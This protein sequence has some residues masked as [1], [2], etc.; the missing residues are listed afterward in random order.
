MTVEQEAIAIA[1]E[2][3][4]ANGYDVDD[5]SA[6]GLVLVGMAIGAAADVPTRKELV[7]GY[8]R[9]YPTDVAGAVF[10][11]ARRLNTGARR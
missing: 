10:G 2:Y 6:V 5:R 4:V 3:A 9:Q 8:I 1:T 11:W 7:A